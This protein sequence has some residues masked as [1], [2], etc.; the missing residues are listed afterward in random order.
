MNYYNEIDP[1]CVEWLENLI[2]AGEIPKG[3]VDA[4]SI[5]DVDPSDLVGYT[6]CHFFAGIA[7][8][9]F[10]ARLAE[11]PEDREL[12]TG[13]CP[14]QPFSA[15]GLRKGEADER[16]LWPAFYR[17]VA[18]RKP[19]VVVGEQVASA[20]GREWLQGVFDDLEDARYAVAGADLCAAGVTAPHI[21]QRLYWVGYADDPRL[22]GHAGDGEH[23]RQAQADRPDAAASS[24]VPWDT[25]D[26]ITDRDGFV[27]RCEPGLSPMAVRLPAHVGLLRAYGNVIIPQVGE[28][29][30]RSVM[31]CAP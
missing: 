4:R 17:L 16:H 9:S 19:S 27:R 23:S 11:W 6:Q 22:E 7:G 3:H 26:A 24:A 12:W 13:S 25:F 30:L 2:Y 8:W 31:E 20:D 5:V 10:A 1:Y 21:R 28:R 29:F 18:E 14:C 15:I